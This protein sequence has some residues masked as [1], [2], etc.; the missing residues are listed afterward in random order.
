[1]AEKF[2]EIVIS[3]L[4]NRPW[5]AKNPCLSP[6]DYWFWS[7]CLQELRRTPPNTIEEL[8]ETV[9]DVTDSLEEEE[10][11]KAVGNIMKRAESSLYDKGGAIEYKLKKK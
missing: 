2:G 4:T 1:M 3:K 8:I 9:N 11:R 7:V 6:L 5:P 10:V